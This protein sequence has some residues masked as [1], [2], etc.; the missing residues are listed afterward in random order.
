MLFVPEYTL[1][2]VYFILFL[3]LAS[4]VEDREHY[5]FEIEAREP[6]FLWWNVTH[7]HIGQ[8]EL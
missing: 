4:Q 5:N 1:D 6:I 7:R 3:Q 8:C 2:F